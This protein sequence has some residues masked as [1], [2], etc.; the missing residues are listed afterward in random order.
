[1]L[2]YVLMFNLLIAILSKTF[3]NISDA[4]LINFQ[5]LRAQLLL[6]WLNMPPAPPPLRLLRLPYEVL[7]VAGSVL[8]HAFGHTACGRRVLRGLLCCLRP[9]GRCCG[10]AGGGGPLFG[11][12]WGLKLPLGEFKWIEQTL[13]EY[14]VDYATQRED[15]VGAEDRWR[16]QLNKSIT[17]KMTAQE[18][19][20]KAE[21]DKVWKAARAPLTR[22]ARPPRP[23]LD[24][25]PNKVAPPR[26]LLQAP[27][28]A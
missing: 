8:S 20:M 15:E 7:S 3:D 4:S 13:H 6:N 2:A 1:M 27:L 18:R 28:M 21:L 9:F 19:V 12:E 25:A 26:P 24:L 5:L 22:V 23:R 10:G 17:S 14:V 11:R 16:I